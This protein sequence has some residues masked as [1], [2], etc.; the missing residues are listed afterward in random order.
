M[1]ADDFGLAP[2]VNE[3]IEEGHRRGILSAASLM[4]TAIAAADAVAACVITP[5]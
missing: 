1:T 3:A 2:E 4:V 5:I